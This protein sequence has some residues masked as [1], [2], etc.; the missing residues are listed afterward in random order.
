MPAEMENEEGDEDYV[1]RSRTIINWTKL[2]T[3]ITKSTVTGF[4]M[5]GGEKGQ[6]EIATNKD[7]GID[8][9]AEN[10]TAAELLKIHQRYG[11]VSFHQLKEMSKQ[12]VIIQKFSKCQIPVCST[13]LFAKATRKR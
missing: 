11:H 2:L 4:S 1:S 10:A 3:P 9:S 13:C 8:S 12:G 7:R 5:K 6:E